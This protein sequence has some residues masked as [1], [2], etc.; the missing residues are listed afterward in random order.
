MDNFCGDDIFDVYENYLEHY[1]RSLRDGADI[2]SGRWPLGY[3]ENPFQ[4]VSGFRGNYLK[5]KAE[6]LSRTEI[7]KKMGM[8]TTTF[9]KLKTIMV[10]EERAYNIATAKKLSEKGYGATKIAEL[11]SES[12]GEII[13]ESTV[14]SWIKAANEGKQNQ[15]V[16][17]AEMLKQLVA[18]KK[19]I[20]VTKGSE[21]YIGDTGV[22]NGTLSAAVELLKQEGYKVEKVKI[23]QVTNPTNKTT[24]M[25]LTDGSL[26]WQDLVNNPRN[27]KPIEEFTPDGGINWMKMQYPASISSDRVK[28]I[29]RDEGGLA[30]DGLIELR[31]GVADISLGASN[32]AQV[33]IAVDDTHYLKGMAMYNPNL[34]PGIDIA[35]NTNKS[36]DVPMKGPKNNT[37]LKP[38]EHDEWDPNNP[39]GSYVKM[40]GGQSYY[41]DSKGKFKKEGNGYILADKNTPASERYSLSAI[42]KLKEEGDWDTQS[43]TL[44][45]QFLSKQPMY[46]IRQQINKTY[47]EKLQEFSEIKSIPNAELRKQLLMKFADTCEGDAVDLKMAQLPRQTS[48]VLLP[49]PELKDNEIYAPTFKN[50]ETVVVIRHPHAGTFEIPQLKVNNNNAV[51]KKLIGNAPDAVGINPYVAG[52]LSGADF[53]GDSGIVIPVSDKV[54]IRTDKPLKGLEGF[55]PKLEYKGYEGMVV[56]TDRQK[57]IEMGKASNL[58][59]DMTLQGVHVGA[60]KQADDELVRA[61]KYS[62]VVVDAKKHELDYKRAY[63]E[64]RISDLQKKYQNN[65]T[66]GAATLIS[67][68]KGEKQVPEFEKKKNMYKPN[69]EGLWEYEPTGRT[70]N[71]LQAKNK[72]TGKWD[73]VNSKKINLPEYD[74]QPTRWKENIPA[75]QDV[76]KMWY[77]LQTTGDANNLVLGTIQEKAYAEYANNMWALAKNARKEF[78]STKSD[79][80]NAA[81]KKT[82]AEEVN[83]LKAKLNNAV[84]NAPKER[85]AQRIA[86]ERIKVVMDSNDYISSDDLGKMRNRILSEARTEVGAT[87]KNTL[88]KI[89]EREWEAIQAGALSA[90]TLSKIIENTDLDTLKKMAMPRDSR[91]LTSAQERK[92][93]SMYNQK[94]AN[95]NN[96]YSISMI[97]EALN[98]SPSTV[99]TYLK[100]G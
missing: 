62:M 39:F 81:A 27:I 55:D 85:E 47:N 29:Y 50:G 14:R 95:G 20:D 26:T 28:I 94:D 38:F 68:A 56:M 83:S 80:Q 53:D 17:T 5:Y 15:I 52:Q 25:V 76:T 21:Y 34:P 45:S 12:T 7:A 60:S 24:T 37:V 90:T 6:G 1:G 51:A 75:M 89:T 57:G 91:A 71:Q 65:P 88:V 78:L 86:G 63:D 31:P 96:K 22:S 73:N 23:P 77:T 13:G 69:S 66:G 74:G 93:L 98:I 82:Y 97:A 54:K 100:K 16:N 9:D 48:R 2:G 79:K 42:N 33:R 72:E 41:P 36:S 3:G 92:I 67:K 40:P 59:T 8:S 30:K 49:V 58:I 70:Y 61:V 84:K 87:R 46:L 10:N 99:S 44:S 35:F 32:Y 43:K 4:H 11:M 64:L 19:A 18:D